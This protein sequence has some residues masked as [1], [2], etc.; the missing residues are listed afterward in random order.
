MMLYNKPI[1]VSSLLFLTGAIATACNHSVQK[2]DT[3]TVTNT[4]EECSPLEATPLDTID[5]KIRCPLG[6]DDTSLLFEDQQ[7]W[8]LWLDRCY[9][10]V[11]APNI[12]FDTHDVIGGLKNI[13]NS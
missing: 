9:G 1:L 11:S 5:I 2:S 12:D 6:S 3:T 10:E 7:S 8:D 13:C 4:P